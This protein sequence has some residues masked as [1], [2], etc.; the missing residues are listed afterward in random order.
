M[1]RFPDAVRA[2]S[3]RASRTT[4]ILRSSPT[5][6]RLAL[7][8]AALV[9]LPGAPAFAAHVTSTWVSP[10]SGSWTNPARWSNGAP[11]NNGV[12]TYD[13]V[14]GAPGGPYTVTLNTAITLTSFTLSAPAATFDHTGGT[15]AVLN[16]INVSA[17]TYQFNGGTLSGGTVNLS[18][19]GTIAFTGGT[20]VLSGTVVNGG[21]TV[22]Q[23]NARARLLNGARFTGDATVSGSGSILNFEHDATLAAG[24]TVTL[25]HDGATLGIARDSTSSTDSALTVAA[26]AAVRGRGR[27]TSNLFSG[28]SAN[29]VVNHGTVAADAGAG[30]LTVD[31]TIFVN[32]G[33]LTSSGGATLS[34][35]GASFTNDGGVTG[36]GGAVNL[37]SDTWTNAAGRTIAMTGGTLTTAGAWSNAGTISIN[38]ATLNLGGTFTTAGIN[39]PNFARSGG[40]VNLTGTLDN[41]GA[42]LPLTAATGS[43]RVDGGTIKGGTITRAGGADLTFTSST[44]ILDGATVVG[45]VS[46]SVDSA[47]ARLK[48]GADFTGNATL[49]STGGIINYEYDATI[50]AGRTINLDGAASS[51]G[52]ARNETTATDSTL[53]IAPGATV[54]GRGQITS[55][56]F[57]SGTANRLVN[58]GTIAADLPNTGLTVNPNLFT[59]HG[60]VKAVNG[61]SLTISSSNWSNAAGG[62]ALASGAST[63]N[64][65]GTWSS[66]G[67]ISLASG[68]TLNMGGTFST[69]GLN[70]GGFNR[71]GATTVNLTGHL[72]NAASTLALTG[73]TGSWRLAGGSISGGTITRAGGADLVFTASSGVL[74]NASVV[75][76]VSFTESNARVRMQNG[77]DFTGNASLS[78]SGALLNYEYDATI[79]PGRTINLENAGASLGIAGSVPSTL[80]I[81]PGATVRGRGQISSGVFTGGTEHRVVNNGTIAADVAAA[82]LVI[83]AYRLTNNGVFGATGGSTFT[84]SSGSWT[85]AANGRINLDAS[86][87]TFGGNW[88]NAGTVTLA[89]G[90]TLSLAGTTSGAGLGLA[91]FVRSGTTTVNLIGAVDNAGG[92]ITLGDASGVVRLSGGT[93]SG[94][95]IVR[96]GGGD[97]AFTSGAGALVGATLVGDATFN[98]SSARLRLQSGGDFTGSATLSASGAI[99]NYEYDATIGLGRTINLENGGASLGIAQGPG[100]VDSTLTIAGMVRGRGQL[101]SGNFSGGS[102][103]AV[104]NNGL[105]FADVNGG[106]LTVNPNRLTNNGTLQAFGSATLNVS[107][108]SFTNAGGR[109]RSLAGGRIRVTSVAGNLNDSG[110]DGPGGLLDLDGAAYNINQPVS[111]T[112]HAMLYLRGGWQ[113]NA[114]AN[115]GGRVVFD[116]PDPDPDPELTNS[117][118]DTIKAQVISGYNNGAWNG[119]GINSA[120]AAANANFGVAYAESR[121]LFPAGNGGTW[122]GHSVDDHAVLVAYTRNGDTD[123]NF[124]VNLAD[125][126]KLAANFGQTGKL[127]TDGDFDYNGI[128]NLTDFNKLAANFGLSAAG[129]DVSPEDWA[130]L[131]SAVPE[132]GALSLIGVAVSAAARRRRRRRG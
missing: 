95:T 83:T 100:S 127:W 22:D 101:T 52:V 53:T 75:G 26:G 114:D 47:R 60:V 92:T 31:P 84:I 85:N 104:V 111:V 112:N 15:L 42:T 106:T 51:L 1:R 109:L 126:N 67:S 123:L 45:D 79:G 131:A 21:L 97:L 38:N 119:P 36:S 49:G 130:A 121:T 71:T 77:G 93:I 62:T 46:M 124:T 74:S 30:T 43:W 11:F 115:V 96:R 29:R 12:N 41:A 125:F 6:K 78:S 108:A 59:N 113:K 28:G 132:P 122:A 48:N 18:G 70:L 58:S 88:S 9:A 128:V 8:A 68:A 102:N 19:A 103:N 91:K 32:H 120:Q 35:G 118:F 5:R 17:G 89:N 110:A 24:Q 16:P 99:L 63:L 4:S 55:G 7:A 50:G 57:S 14:I 56:N 90:A 39:L 117:P 27:I 40:T 80:T 23:F 81:A 98:E 73:T 25:S 72:N 65:S 105:I 13:A 116:Y 82:G 34:I 64:F 61:A 129:P 76:D 44:G 54:R 87:G 94:G 86:T 20:G 3:V 69:S 10:V 66:P 2:P 33:A 37:K 107:A